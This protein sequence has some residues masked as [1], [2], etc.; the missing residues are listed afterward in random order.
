MGEQGV[1]GVTRL[2]RLIRSIGKAALASRLGVQP[3]TVTRW[4]KRGIPKGRRKALAAIEARRK[5]A[6][7][8][9][10]T[11]TAER[12]RESKAWQESPYPEPPP[13]EPP[14]EPPHRD[15]LERERPT[16][17]RAPRVEDDGGPDY[18]APEVPRSDRDDDAGDDDS[19]D[20]DSGD[21]DSYLDYG[22]GDWDRV[23]DDYGE[24]DDFEWFSRG[25]P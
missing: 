13:R 1:K 25:S 19:G 14:R 9:A 15:I 21:D 2:G 5:A 20:D 7:K 10:R 3:A 8:G 12:A 4:V 18:P 16:F 24:I 23:A 17:Q 22:P 11:R 6:R